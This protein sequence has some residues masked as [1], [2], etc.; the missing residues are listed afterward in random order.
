MA[1]ERGQSSVEYLALLAVVAAALAL[2][3]GRVVDAGTRATARAASL[4]AP[5]PARPSPRSQVARLIDAPLPV[6]LAE[7]SSPRRD[8]RLD[9]ST[10]GC[11]APVVGSEGRSFDFLGPCLRHDF[12]YRN[13]ERL[14]LFTSR[15]KRH[16]DDVFLADMRA[17]CDRRRA[18]LVRTGCRG[19]AQLFFWAVVWFG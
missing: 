6:F 4:L 14:G 8:A 1:V 10:D 5:G 15:A 9:W 18:K 3:G 12:G 2:G 7:R 19:W 13:L 17:A 11:S 16:V